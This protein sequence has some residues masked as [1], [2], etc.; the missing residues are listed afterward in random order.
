MLTNKKSEDTR[1]PVIIWLAK[2]PKQMSPAGG[3]E[4]KTSQELRKPPYT[5][6]LESQV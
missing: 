2:Y 4:N 1:S 5:S 3:P 6:Y